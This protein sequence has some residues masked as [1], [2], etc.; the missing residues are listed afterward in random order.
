MLAQAVRVLAQLVWV[1]V[2]AVRAQV[3]EAE[4]VQA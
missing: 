4:P 2:W 3:V 1:Q